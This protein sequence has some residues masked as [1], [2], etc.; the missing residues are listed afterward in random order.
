MESE[1]QH[2]LD[3]KKS[4]ELNLKNGLGDRN[5]II[6]LIEKIDNS[7]CVNPNISTT[8]KSLKTASNLFLNIVRN[9]S[10]L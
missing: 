2:W 7:L 4:Y 9:S 10:L 5:S 1:I 6:A 3:T 8:D